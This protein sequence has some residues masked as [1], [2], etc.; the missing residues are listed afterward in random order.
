MAL[1]KELQEAPKIGEL[2]AESTGE[3]YGEII[4]DYKPGPG[5]S[6][7]FGRPNYARVNKTY[8]DHRRMKHNDGTLEALV[9]RVVKNWEVDSHHVLKPSDWKTMNADKFRIS[10]NGGPKASAQAMADVG[11]Y[12]ALLGD[13][14]GVFY[15]SQQTFASTNKIF[16]EV[17]PE[18]Y[19][20]ECLE[21]Y[22]GP[23]RISFKWRH[24]GTFSGRWVA[25]DGTEYAGTGE[26]L[27]LE[28]MCIA[29]VDDEL[30]IDELEIFYNPL[31]QIMPLLR[32]EKTVPPRSSGLFACCS[33]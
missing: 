32:G 33:A 10:V 26:V 13:I 18:G 21:V 7:R 15:A 22:Q 17:F 29:T 5:V 31:D 6:W 20:W 23:P 24:F 16:S 4:R 1:W 27:N 9:N 25:P 14:P 28:G 3:K 11:P 8:F 12:V 30:K 19:A 2:E